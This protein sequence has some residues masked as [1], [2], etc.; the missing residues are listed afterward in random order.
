M[1][2]AS[3]AA[4]THES[5]FFVI[6]AGENPCGV[7]VLVDVYDGADR[8]PVGNADITFTNLETGATYV[9]RSRYV[10]TWTYDASSES[11]DGT[12]KGRKWTPWFPG[13]PGPSGEVQ[14]PGLWILT[15]GKLEYTLDGNDVATAFTLHGTYIDLCAELTT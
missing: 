6:P 8:A 5:F 15:F 11:W 2:A 1:F 13:E 9:Q 7:D 10:E 12:V 3:P 4:A 14:E